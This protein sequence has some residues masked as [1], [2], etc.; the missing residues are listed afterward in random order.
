MK[1]R[2]E[3]FSIKESLRFTFAGLF[4]NNF[5]P[6]TV[7]GDVVRLAGTMQAGY[8]GVVSGASL[9]V[10]RLVGMAGMALAL[11]VVVVKLIQNP[12]LWG[13]TPLYVFPF[14]ASV[15]EEETPG[16]FAKVKNV[17]GRI[18]KA[19]A[20]WIKQP[21]VLILSFLFT[22]AHMAFLFGAIWVLLDAMGDS[23][24]IW[25]VGG[26]YAFAYFVTLIP[27]SINGL[28]VQEV[29][30]TF[31]FSTL[32]GISETNSLT[33]SLLIRTLFML[34][35]LPGAVFI[36]GIMPGVKNETGAKL[37]GFFNSSQSDE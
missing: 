36:P 25:L 7:G 13:Q 31:A 27:I 28:G 19:I 12:S 9:I 16:L 11:P 34:A 1:A 24:S 22:L 5:L 35:S 14:L 32:G 21:R 26:F 8:D 10:D 37:K 33:L 29:A 30:I 23:L 18:W 4:A 2:E 6:S 20:V 15:Q 3:K 17:L